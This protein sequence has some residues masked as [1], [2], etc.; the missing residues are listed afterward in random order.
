M[1][2]AFTFFYRTRPTT[3]A[4]IWDELQPYLDTDF[5]HV[6]WGT[7]IGGD[8][9][10]YPSDRLTRAGHDQSDFPRPGDRNVAESLRILHDRGVDPL[11]TALE[12][13]HAGGLAFHVGHRME[14]FQMCPPFDAF[15]T[16]NLWREHPEWRCRDRDGVEI[17]RLSYAFD[18][19]QQHVLDVFQ[20][21]LDR[22]Q[23]DGINPIFNRGAPYL[24][25]EEPLTAAYPVNPRTLDERDAA[26]LQFRAETMTGFMRLLRDLV[27]A[28]AARRG[29]HLEISPHVLHDLD[30]NLFYG[31][32]VETWIREG[33]V[34]RVIAFP[35]RDQTVDTSAF[36][37]LTR[38]TGVAFFQDIM[39]R[40]LS[41]ADYQERARTLFDA[42]VDGLCFWDT[43]QRAPRLS[44]WCMLRRLST[45]ASS[46]EPDPVVRRVPLE[47]VAG[48]RV[49]RY[50][51]HW[52]F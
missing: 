22:Y 8:L 28:A 23:V 4:D 45:W 38:G 13:A 11:A 32:D 18:G 1:D 3:Q 47:S 6:F 48:M 31:L 21:I 20:E 16:G 33:L 29:T 17:A 25:Y 43:D 39:P 14:S 26:W 44:E 49:D 5:T 24:L 15:F 46:S 41:A 40:F 34:D 37:D 36:V 2:D 19:V 50:P 52:A 9:G 35:W 10:A 27:D 42:G 7:G 51:P 12:F 30:T